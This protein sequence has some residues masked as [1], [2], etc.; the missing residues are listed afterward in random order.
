MC[1]HKRALVFKFG[2]N[3]LF[4]DIGMECTTNMFRW[5]DIPAM[6]DSNYEEEELTHFMEQCQ[7]YQK[8]LAALVRR[9]KLPID[10]PGDS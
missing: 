10:A 2:D 6:K 8:N 4:T 3:K 9:L 5:T 7:S 1:V